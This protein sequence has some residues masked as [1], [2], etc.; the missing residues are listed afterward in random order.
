[1]HL[2][3]LL[4]LLLRLWLCISWDTEAVLG[5]AVRHSCW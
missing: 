1:M 3:L 5:S 2:L 4:L